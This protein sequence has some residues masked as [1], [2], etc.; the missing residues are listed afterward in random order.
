MSRFH[1]YLEGLRKHPQIQSLVE[2]VE[3]YL[4]SGDPAALKLIVAAKDRAWILGSLTAVMS[5]PGAMDDAD[6]RL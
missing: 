2:P 6:R 4:D 3:R 1:N 5:K